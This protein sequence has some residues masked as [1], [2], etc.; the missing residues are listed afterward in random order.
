MPTPPGQRARRQSIIDD[1]PVTCHWR[2]MSAHDGFELLSPLN[3]QQVRVRFGGHF[4]GA[5]VIWEA[6]LVSLQV[7]A[8]PGDSLRRFIEIGPAEGGHR[9]V[10][11]GLDVAVI[12]RPTIL[13]AQVMLRQY[14]RLREGRHE[15]GPRI[16]CE[17]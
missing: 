6:T 4:E 17:S 14:K 5:P 16:H 1:H 10:T 11:V 15:Y 7:I 12:D 3:G 2:D 8:R 13:K 9:P